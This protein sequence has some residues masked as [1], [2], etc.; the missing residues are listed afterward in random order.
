MGEELAVTARKSINLAAVCWSGC[1]YTVQVLCIALLVH[2]TLPWEGC[3][4]PTKHTDFL[5]SV[6]TPRE[7][8]SSVFYDFY[9]ILQIW[10]NLLENDRLKV[11]YTVLIVF[12][13]CKQILIQP[14]LRWHFIFYSLLQGLCSSPSF[15]PYLAWLFPPQLGFQDR[16]S[17]V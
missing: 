11:V 3:Q 1:N 4:K 9:Y 5:L 17:V 14:L 12:A 13:L 10:G 15:L 8:V 6:L 16:K 7:I 2:W